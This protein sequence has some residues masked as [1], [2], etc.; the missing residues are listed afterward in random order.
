[1]KTETIAK[2]IIG[3]IIAIIII[4]SIFFSSGCTTHKNLYP[5]PIKQND[6]LKIHQ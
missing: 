5:P 1:M 2:V 4:C 6:Y 3:F